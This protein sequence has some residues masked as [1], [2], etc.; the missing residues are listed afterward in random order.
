MSNNKSTLVIVKTTI[1]FIIFTLSAILCTIYIKEDLQAVLD[2]FTLGHILAISGL[3]LI[4][5]SL[6]ILVI[7]TQVY[8][9]LIV[10]HDTD[11]Y[12][13]INEEERRYNKVHAVHD[14][15]NITYNKI[16]IR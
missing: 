12:I 11:P 2:T 16:V 14:T 6:A 1:A 5:G 10:K 13:N 15:S 9:L 7:H 3:S 4:I 8:T